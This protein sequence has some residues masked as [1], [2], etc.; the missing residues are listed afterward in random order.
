M[1]K[2]YSV[3]KRVL[4]L[5]LFLLGM[6]LL[7]LMYYNYFAV[8]ELNKKTAEA[9]SNTLY[10]QCQNMEKEMESIAAAMVN[11]TSEQV[12]FQRL[13]YKEYLQYDRGAPVS[14]DTEDDHLPVESP[15]LYVKRAQ[16]S[17]A[18]SGRIKL[19]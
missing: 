4:L 2:S 14:D 9:S 18:A 17:R 10:I 3:K 19:Y 7:I 16:K 6:V 5:L 12:P 1:A 8:S 13:A 11:L 15:A